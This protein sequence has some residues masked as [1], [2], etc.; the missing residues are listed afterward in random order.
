M[1]VSGIGEII[2]SRSLHLVDDQGYERPVRVFIGK[3]EPSADYRGY[4]CPFQIIGIGSQETRVGFGRD[5]VQALKTTL[6]LVTASLNHLNDELG[7]KL[8]W[9]GARKIP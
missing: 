1:E 9:N 4:E 8:V 5:S 2:A 3:P 6:V 7:G